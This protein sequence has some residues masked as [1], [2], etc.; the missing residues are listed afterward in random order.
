MFIKNL[1][2]T[3]GFLSRPCQPSFNVKQAQR[4]HSDRFANDRVLYL[5]IFVGGRPLRPSCAIAHNICW[6]YEISTS[7]NVEVSRGR[8]LRPWWCSL[9]AL[10]TMP[11]LLPYKMSPQACIPP[12]LPMIM[13][14]RSPSL[15]V[16]W[17]S[18]FKN[19]SS[20]TTLVNLFVFHANTFST[21]NEPR[22]VHTRFFADDHVL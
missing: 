20:L 17:I 15:F 5:T 19:T 16:T 7:K 9:F 1:R 6:W 11:A 2:Y 18:N 14:Y 3:A 13:C 4:A 12:V 21:S 8:P 10:M 22:S